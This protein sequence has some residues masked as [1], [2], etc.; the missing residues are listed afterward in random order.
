MSCPRTKHY[1][2]SQHS[3]LD[4]SIHI[5]HTRRYHTYLPVVQS[6][7]EIYDLGSLHQWGKSLVLTVVR[8]RALLAWLSLLC[9]WIH[10]TLHIQEMNS[11]EMRMIQNLKVSCQACVDGLGEM[12][13]SLAGMRKFG[14]SWITVK[15]G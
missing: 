13:P 15:S 11:V 3:N 10:L 12:V 7:H 6:W 2:L 9:V 8:G 4:C 5:Q 14:D 1:D